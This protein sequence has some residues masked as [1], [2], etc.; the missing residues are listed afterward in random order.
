[1]ANMEMQT[2]TNSRY[3]ASTIQ[4][5]LIDDN[6]S[7]FPHGTWADPAVDAHDV[8]REYNHD[9]AASPNLLVAA[10]TANQKV[11][12]ASNNLHTGTGLRQHIFQLNSTTESELYASRVYMRTKH[13]LSMS[14]LSTSH[15]SGAGLSFLSKISLTQISSISVISLPLCCNEL[16]NPQQYRDLETPPYGGIRADKEPFPSAILPTSDG[17]FAGRRKGVLDAVVGHEEERSVRGMLKSRSKRRPTVEK[18]RRK[19]RSTGERQRQT[20]VLLLGNF[21]LAPP[22][23]FQAC[24]TRQ[25]SILI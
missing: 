21:T 10:S 9:V 3:A 14:S 16:W 4:G 18:L 22:P 12:T 15:D 19:L 20:K 24:P 1:M 25:V 7:M 5:S 8:E 2:G 17:Q 6:M 23:L 11:Q 13:R